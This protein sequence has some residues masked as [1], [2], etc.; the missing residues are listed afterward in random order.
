MTTPRTI[1]GQAALSA[2]RPHF[3][4]ALGGTIVAIETQA[5]APYLA[6]L[7]D[8]E[9][10]LGDLAARDATAPWDR[11]NQADFVERAE[12]ARDLVRSLLDQP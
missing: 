1:A 4:R 2:L 6:A 10:L 3:K 9:R 7:K 5:I 8:V 11:A 12:A